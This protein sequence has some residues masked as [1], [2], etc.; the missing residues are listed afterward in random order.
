MPAKSPPI[1]TSSLSTFLRK[2]RRTCAAF[3]E[4]PPVDFDFR[5]GGDPVRSPVVQARNWRRA[6]RLDEPL[7]VA[8]E[9]F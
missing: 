2:G 4:G 6:D 5:D 8:S 3:S 9:D 1:G 7:R